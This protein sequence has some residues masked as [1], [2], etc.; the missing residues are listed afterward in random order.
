MGAIW[1]VW[2]IKN[3]NILQI[4]RY[5]WGYIVNMSKMEYFYSKNSILK[6]KIQPEVAILIF[7][8][9]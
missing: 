8:D 6:I 4:I 2:N 5:F 9:R 3:I 1:E 7:T